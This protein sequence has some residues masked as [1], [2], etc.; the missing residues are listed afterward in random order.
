M[1]QFD[2]L[3]KP[4]KLRNLV[5]R[6]RVMSTGHAS[7]FGQDGNPGERYI[8]YHEEKAKGGVAL[9]MIGGSANVALDS[10]SSFGQL[11]VGDDDVIPYFQELARR[12]HAHGAADVIEEFP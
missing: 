2:A 1:G 3:L 11:Y 8:L 7:G 9:T 6:N 10:P 12:V 5:I 4:L